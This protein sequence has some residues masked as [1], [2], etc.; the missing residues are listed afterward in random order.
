MFS[1][2]HST[3]RSQLAILVVACVLPVWLVAGFLVVHAYSDKRNQINRNMLETARAMTMVVDRELSSVQAALQALATSPAFANGNFAVVH[4][5]ALELLK[6][7]PGAD[8]IVADVTGQQ[9][10][11]SYR[12]Y[13]DSLPKR[14]TLE[15]VRSIFESGK[16]LVSDLY[17]GAVTKRP[18]I[19]ID[20]PVFHDGKVAYDLAMTFPSDRLASILAQQKLPKGW[21]CSILDSKRVIVARTQDP[22]KYVGKQANSEFR[23]AMTKAQEGTTE[24]HSVGGTPVL[25]SFCKSSMSEW[26]VAFG[27]SKAVVMTETYQWMGWAIGG[28]ATISLIGIIFA[29]GIA[30]RIA[31]DIQALVNPALSIGRGELVAAIDDLSVKETGEVATALVQASELL[32]RRARERDEAEWQLSRTIDLLQEE[33]AERLRATEALLER[34][35]MLIQQSRLAALGEM[36]RNIAHQWRQPLNV[37]GLVAQELPLTYQSGQFNKEYL[38]E[39][40]E[41]IKEVIFHMSRTINDFGNFFRPDKEKQLFK[42]NKV[43]KQTLSLIEESFKELDVGLEIEATGE[44]VIDG[45]PNEYSQALINILLNARDAFLE[46]KV[47]KPWVV[48]INMFTEE[49]RAVV[50]I[51]DNAGGIPEDIMEKIFDPYFTTKKPD[52]GTGVGLFMTNTIIAKSMGGSV[53]ARNIGEGAEFRIEVG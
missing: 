9:L 26:A 5:Q 45:Y 20:V 30:R 51:T 15:T 31:E 46:G 19:G 36:I 22:E 11:N 53:K 39:R 48:K 7:Y 21:Y 1:R 42:V 49:T 41:K 34:E 52:K 3:I 14:K 35:R 25:A 29:L 18:M 27:V 32:Q 17:Y 50:T 44:P 2:P 13:G 37:V 6:S 24:V 33:T 4:R 38:D 23:Q 40:V 28:A 47:G 8:I 43:V 16:P 12:P 10:V